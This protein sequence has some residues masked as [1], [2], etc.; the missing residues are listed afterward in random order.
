[1]KYEV[2]WDYASSMGGPWA[3]GEIVEIDPEQAEWFNRDSPGVLKKAPKKRNLE[4]PP[5]HRMVTEGRRR[6]RQGEPGDQGP[7]TK[8]DFKAVKEKE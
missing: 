6:D 7:I 8:S 5:R 3:K 1:M 4:T 2:Q